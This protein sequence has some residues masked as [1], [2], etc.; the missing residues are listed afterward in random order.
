M[1]EYFFLQITFV[2]LSV[3]LLIVY[4]LS[5]YFRDT[6]IESLTQYDAQKTSE[7]TFEIISAKI[8]EG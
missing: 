8:Q 3:S 6:A 4:L 1:L 2:T 5:S 7:L